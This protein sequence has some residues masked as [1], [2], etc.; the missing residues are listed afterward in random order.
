MGQIEESRG[1]FYELSAEERAGVE[2]GLADADA[3]RFATD[4]EVAA[5]FAKFRSE[6][7]KGQGCS[8]LLSE[9]GK[10]QLARN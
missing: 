1:I 10:T 5:V 6:P 4:E 9:S 2:R 8:V 7:G 3:G